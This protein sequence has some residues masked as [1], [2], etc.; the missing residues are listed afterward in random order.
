MKPFAILVVAIL[1]AV[2][3]GWHPAQGVP[4]SELAVRAPSIAGHLQVA[5]VQT[6]GGSANQAFFNQGWTLNPKQSRV[7]M[8]SVKKNSL[9]ET[10]NF[11]EVEGNIRKDGRA[12][13]IIN[14]ASLDTGIDIRNVRMRFLLFE[15]FKF[16]AAE[17]SATLDKAMF[18]DLLIQRRVI[19]DI[20]FTLN[21]HGV[22]KEVEAKVAVTRILDDAVSV[23]T[24]KPVI[25]NASDFGLV[26]GVDQLAEAA[27]GFNIVPAA[28]VTFD[29]MFEGTN[30]NPEIEAARVAAARLRAQQSQG[31]ITSVACETRLDVIS[32]TRAIY[33]RTGSAE[34]D[35]ESEPLLNSVAEI[36]N[37]CQAVKME[38]AGHTD[39]D[40]S[41]A[42]NQILSEQ[43]ARA[44]AVY[45]EQKGVATV[46]VITSGHGDTQPVAA[47][48]TP[49]NK[50]KN[51][52][53]EF[54]I[55]SHQA[56]N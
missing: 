6:P 16:P 31:G 44:V 55:R 17:I 34:L 26:A 22:E 49:A 14:L 3:A 47:N 56:A 1:T 50:A 18:K 53:I 12:S 33:F 45:L 43:R 41:K 11:T 9:F 24:V 28:S 2:V 42:S 15:T 27:G 19:R 46:R 10:H 29:L 54:R 32:K 25:V 51:R 7:F 30:F 5:Q 35:S 20:V 48:D 23:S 4:G 13:V 40:G 21:L 37:R 36:V 39:S 38:I 52:R 8:Q